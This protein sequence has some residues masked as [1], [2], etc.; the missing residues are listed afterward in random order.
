MS[1]PLYHLKDRNTSHF[2]SPLFKPDSSEET[3]KF[4]AEAV[5]GVRSAK[6]IRTPRGPGSTDVI[7]ASV[8][9]LPSPELIADVEAALYDHE[10]MGFDVQVKAPTVANV[11]IDI[12]FSGE[13][14]EADIALIAEAYVHDLGIG[15]RFALKDLYALYEPLGLATVEII[16]PGRDVQAGEAS[17]ITATINVSKVGQ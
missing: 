3:Y 11:S 7:V 5:A 17:I 14:D 10:L 8:T 13:A 12:E 9:G 6:I 16:S 4:Y 2:V 15:G 1:I